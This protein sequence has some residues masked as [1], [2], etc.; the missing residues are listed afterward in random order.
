[1]TTAAVK[2]KG[3]EQYG[4]NIAAWGIA[5]EDKAQAHKESQACEESTAC[6]ETGK[7]ASKPKTERANKKADVISMMKRAKGATEAEIM[8][9]TEC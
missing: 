9:A 1:V 6:R 7:P 5:A 8:A 4:L 3:D 2:E